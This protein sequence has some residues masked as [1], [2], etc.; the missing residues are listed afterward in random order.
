[1]YYRCLAFWQNEAKRP[2]LPEKTAVSAGILAD[3]PKYEKGQ[4]RRS[5]AMPHRSVTT[6]QGCFGFSEGRNLE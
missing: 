6:T 2:E 3:L 5:P 1:M 4:G